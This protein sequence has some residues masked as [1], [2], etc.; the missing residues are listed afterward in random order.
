MAYKSGKGYKVEIEVS[1]GSYAEIKAIS[2][3]F[4]QSE[5][6]DTFY[7]LASDIANNVKTAL[8][9]TYSITAK[10]DTSDT[11]AQYLLGLEFKTGA[12]AVTG[13]K[14][15]N[16]NEGTTG[17]LIE[18]EGLISNIEYENITEDVVEVSFDLKVAD[19]TITK[20][21]VSVSA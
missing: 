11:A 17:Y 9:P 19:G 13:I 6:V 12:D 5:T 2:A 7:T 16:P 1:A 3:G 18:F 4:S 14:I 8:D 20:T 21:A 10:L 15:T